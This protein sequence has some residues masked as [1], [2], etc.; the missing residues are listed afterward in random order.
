[1]HRLW[2]SVWWYS[3]SHYYEQT[4]AF[5]PHQH[6][7][8]GWTTRQRQQQSTQLFYQNNST[9]DSTSSTSSFV[10]IP[11][12]GQLMNNPSPLLMGGTMWLTSPTPLQW[13][14]IE[15]CVE[16]HYQQQ[17]QQQQRTTNNETM[18][19]T[20]DAAP[21]VAILNADTQYAT[22]AAI[23][24]VVSESQT[25]DTR[26]PISF[27]ESL[28]GFLQTPMYRDSSRIRLLG[29]GRATLTG[30]FNRKEEEEQRKDNEVTT[31]ETTTTGEASS[32]SCSSSSSDSENQE[33]YDDDSVYEPVLMAQMKLVC[34]K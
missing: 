9:D 27:R 26:D 10:E 32:S 20:V 29:I 7:L 11:V 15:V 18:H 22:I 34:Q 8:G 1:M 30:F 12:I 2:L 4:T 13:K 24:G 25:I 19:A 21:L 33:V 23:M 14:T 16:Q 17:Q 31:T 28:S 3:L 5:L 6:R